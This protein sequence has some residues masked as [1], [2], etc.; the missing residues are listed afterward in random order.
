MATPGLVV[1]RAQDGRDLSNLG[2]LAVPSR[3]ADDPQLDAVQQ[4][5]AEDAV[6]GQHGLVVHRAVVRVHVAPIAEA[7]G[8]EQGGQVARLES[9]GRFQLALC[10][11]GD[12]DALQL[13]LDGAHAVT[14]SWPLPTPSSG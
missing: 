2:L 1:G 6:A 9:L 8:D 11:R 10:G 4:V 3:V 5:G 13:Q 14:H 7:V 12:D